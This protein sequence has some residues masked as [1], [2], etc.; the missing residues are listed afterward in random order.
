VETSRSAPGIGSF[1]VISSVHNI[2]T[3][4][5]AGK[6]D[7]VMR[8]AHPVHLRATAVFLGRALLLG[9]Q[10]KRVE[11]LTP[12]RRTVAQPLDAAVPA[13]RSSPRP[14]RWSTMVLRCFMS[15]ASAI[16]IDAH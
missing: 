11:L 15:P 5:L 1:P 9:I 7:Q 2:A 12:F 6:L 10:A 16:A 4:S 8:A 3:A 13:A 14:E